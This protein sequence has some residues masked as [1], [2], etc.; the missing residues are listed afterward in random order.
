MNLIETLAE[1]NPEALLWD[2]FD[3]ALIG[4]V[5]RACKPPLALYSASK[6]VE[7]LSSGG[8]DEDEAREYLDFNTFCAYMGDHTPCFL[9]D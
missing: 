8:M 7:V 2:G 5:R 4:V 9:E 1:E 3:D 6:C